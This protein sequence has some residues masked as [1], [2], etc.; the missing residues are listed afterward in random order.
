MQ[1]FFDVSEPN[2]YMRI[3]VEEQMYFETDSLRSAVHTF[4]LSYELKWCMEQ[5]RLFGMLLE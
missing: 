2:V 3:I 5:R 4:T 1:F